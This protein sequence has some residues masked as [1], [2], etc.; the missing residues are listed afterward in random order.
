MSVVLTLKRVKPSSIEEGF[1]RLG[2]LAQYQSGKVKFLGQRQLYPL[3]EVSS[4][5]PKSCHIRINENGTVEI[6][7]YGQRISIELPLVYYELM[8]ILID[9]LQAPTFNAQVIINNS[10]GALVLLK[11]YCYYLERLPESQ[12]N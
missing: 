1:G 8:G 11:W 6:F 7:Y 3:D 2:L 10:H 5:V 4:N 9:I 12:I